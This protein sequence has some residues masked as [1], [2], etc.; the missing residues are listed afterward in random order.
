MLARTALC[1]VVLWIAGAAA[2]PASGV[3]VA[4]F[5][6]A[7]DLTD[8]L[9]Q[10]R[11]T[12]ALPPPRHGLAAARVA[13]LLPELVRYDAEGRPRSVRYR[14]LTSVLLA[15]VERLD[16]RVARLE[17]ELGGAEEATEPLVRIRVDHD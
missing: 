13:E 2:P 8:A 14:L 5:H 3:A 1:C 4:R 7:L 9:I 6:G 15:E 16:T 12:A 11:E 10:L 17:A